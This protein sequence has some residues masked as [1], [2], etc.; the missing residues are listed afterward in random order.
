MFI[1]TVVLSILL[2][3]VFVASGTPKAL[4]NAKT[5]S[6]AEHLNFSAGSYHV[7]GALEVAAAA[8]L[9]IGLFWAP[10]GIA[11]AGGLTLLMVGA[12][13]S[14][15]RVKDKFSLTFPSTPLALV[16]AATVV[17]HIASA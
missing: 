1:A 3:A 9:I 16:S 2:A 5:A 8:G 4:K 13:I 6:A 14:H 17:T 11:A 15:G 10:L 12:A 7:I